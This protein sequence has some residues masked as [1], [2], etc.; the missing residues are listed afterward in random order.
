MA[1]PKGSYGI[2]FTSTDAGTIYLAFKAP[3]AVYDTLAA[4]LG[5][6]K[7][8][9]AADLSKAVYVAAANYCRRVRVSYK[10]GTGKATGSLWV[11]PA[12]FEEATDGSFSGTYRGNE[13]YSVRQPLDTNRS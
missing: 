10:K 6:D 13:V 9:S 2:K 1:D 4:S 3:K 12:K 5:L 8:E 7:L 11:A